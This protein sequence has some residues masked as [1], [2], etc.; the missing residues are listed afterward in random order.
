MIQNCTPRLVDNGKGGHAVRWST[1]SMVHTRDFGRSP[2][3]EREAKAFI[4]ATKAVRAA[5]VAQVMRNA[6]R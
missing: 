4:R 1:G 5:W 3:S 2:T 6:G